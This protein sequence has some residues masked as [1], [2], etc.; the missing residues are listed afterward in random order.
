MTTM[1]IMCREGDGDEENDD[2]DDEE[3]EEEAAEALLWGYG[4]VEP[5][6]ILIMLLTTA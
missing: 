2:D 3:E 5:P 6:T 1:A 4:D